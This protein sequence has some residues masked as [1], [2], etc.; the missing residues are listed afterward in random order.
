MEKIHSF[1]AGKMPY[2]NPLGLSTIEDEVFALPKLPSIVDNPAGRMVEC[3]EM[4]GLSCVLLSGVGFPG[5][6]AAETRMPA[7]RE[8]SADVSPLLGDTTELQLEAVPRAPLYKDQRGC[9]YLVRE[10]AGKER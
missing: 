9:V 5:R 3:S 7:P 4:L 10:P 6:A 2:T 1:V 8:P